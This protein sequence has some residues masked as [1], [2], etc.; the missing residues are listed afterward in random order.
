[1]I[2]KA[3]TYLD[4]TSLLSD[5]Q[6][7]KVN[8]MIKS[9]VNLFTSKAVQKQKTDS[10]VDAVTR[11]S[12]RIVSFTG[13]KYHD[14]FFISGAMDIS[15][16]EE[17]VSTDILALDSDIQSVSMTGYF[18]TDLRLPLSSYGSF[19]CSDNVLSINLSSIP[20]STILFFNVRGRLK[21]EDGTESSS[22][23][24][25]QSYVSSLAKGNN[26][27]RRADTVAQEK[28]NSCIR[29]L[30]NVIDSYEEKVTEQRFDTLS[31]DG[32]YSFSI[33]APSK[34]KE[35]VE[36]YA[37]V[38]ADNIWIGTLNTTGVLNIESS[39][40]TNTENVTV[41]S[42]AFSETKENQFWSSDPDD[43]PTSSQWNG[44]TENYTE[45]Y[46]IDSVLYKKTGTRTHVFTQTADWI[47]WYQDRGEWIWD[48]TITEYVT[49]TYTLVSDYS[50]AE[51]HIFQRYL[52]Q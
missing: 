27:D 41:S 20:E 5:A 25:S 35:K 18:D 30:H 10:M 4:S 8:S 24:N 2:T 39:D 26:G 13:H 34:P 51:I 31:Y 12:K 21:T 48:Y 46:E 49:D 17:G 15:G 9:Q 42:V 47:M 6:I 1:M 44:R 14:V 37:T 3:P 23:E 45:E 11:Y 22:N 7:R 38:G 29:Q 32:K 16:I 19:D 43:P 28:I 33:K 52:K 40:M 36:V 50:N